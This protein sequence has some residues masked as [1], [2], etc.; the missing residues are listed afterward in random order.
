VSKF[1]VTST[2]ATDYGIGDRLGETLLTIESIRKRIDAQI[3]LIDSSVH[4][5]DES[6]VR[7]AVDTFIRLQDTKVRNIIESGYGMPYI[8]S[9][10]E[11]YMMQVALDLIG[12][13]DSRIY[14]LSGRYRLTD[15][16]VPHDGMKFTFLAPM[17]T[18]I[19]YSQC[20]SSG[21]LMTR[22]YSLPGKFCAFYSNFLNL[23][24][25]YLW[26]VYARK[27]ITDIEHGLYKL[28][29]HDLCNFV[30]RIGVE[31]RIGHLSIHIKE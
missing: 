10:T 30:N 29:P 14:K 18:G 15:E 12:E 31:G 9:A 8:K 13:T 22:L 11:S 1:I 20:E 25:N 19:P 28:L 27:G 5:W 17:G 7:E 26:S 4:D 21:M 16:F 3:I 6:P 24:N 2:I 23:L